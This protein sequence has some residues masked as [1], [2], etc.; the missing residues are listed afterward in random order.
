MKYTILGPGGRFLDQAGRHWVDGTFNAGI[1]DTLERA[2]AAAK[3]TG[4][5]CR[6]FRDFGLGTQIEVTP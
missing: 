4:E 6:I 2:R 5:S 3:G 1:W